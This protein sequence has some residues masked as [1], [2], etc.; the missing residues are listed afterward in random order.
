MRSPRSIAQLRSQMRSTGPVSSRSRNPVIPPR[1]SS[2]N[3]LL[4]RYWSFCGPDVR[5]TSGAVLVRPPYPLDAD[6]RRAVSL[7]RAPEGLAAEIVLARPADSIVWHVDLLHASG[8]VRG[9]GKRGHCGQRQAQ[10]GEQ[11]FHDRILDGFTVELLPRPQS[12]CWDARPNPLIR[13]RGGR[14]GRLGTPDADLL[15]LAAITRQHGDHPMFAGT[16]I[17]ILSID[18]RRTHANLDLVRSGRD[19]EHL[20]TIIRYR[21]L[22]GLHV[23][24][25]DER[26]F[27]SAGDDDLSRVRRMCFSQT[28]PTA[29][30]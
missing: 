9:S 20:R 11:S 12:P 6:L 28:E 30:G 16:H 21:R 29:A 5:G 26:A 14:T 1:L 10:Y 19:L 7:E 25:E 17:G 18:E 22:S 4:R 13:A 2:R 8:E 15:V 27:R 23:I 24:D 3:S